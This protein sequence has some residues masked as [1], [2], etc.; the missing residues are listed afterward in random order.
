MGWAV[1]A[2]ICLGMIWGDL[3]S[4]IKGAGPLS[5]TE[6][7]SSK[8]FGASGVNE[9][10]ASQT[11]PLPTTADHSGQQKKKL[12]CHTVQLGFHVEVEA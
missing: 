6:R 2:R 11:F 4:C 12:S 10:R 8:M 5:P 1:H 7:N 9:R 3:G